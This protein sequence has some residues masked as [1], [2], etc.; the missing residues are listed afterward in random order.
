M[1]RPVPQSSQ[2]LPVRRSPSRKR[3]ADSA[4][5]R[6][7]AA[8]APS[9]AFLLV[10]ILHVYLLATQAGPLDGV[11]SID[12]GVRVE[13]IQSLI[14]TRYRSLASVYYGE[15]VDPTRAYTPLLGQYLYRAGKSYSMFS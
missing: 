7:R 9:A 14:A 5:V 6:V 1:R 2:A 3:D 15:F 12:Q 13:Q 11:W 4:P 8:A 10:G